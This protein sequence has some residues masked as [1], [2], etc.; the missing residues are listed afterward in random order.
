MLPTYLISCTISELWR[1]IGQIFAS[2]R[3]SLH[4]N[5]VTGEWF[6]A[7]IATYWYVAKD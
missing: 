3:W 4:F 7:N 2:D 5:A 6:P 1:I